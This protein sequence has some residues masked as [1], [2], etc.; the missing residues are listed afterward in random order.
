MVLVNFNYSIEVI[1]FNRIGRC[2]TLF[3]VN[4]KSFEETIVSELCITYITVVEINKNIIN[5]KTFQLT[6]N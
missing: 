3:E 4:D 1:A 6:K 2:I 5:V